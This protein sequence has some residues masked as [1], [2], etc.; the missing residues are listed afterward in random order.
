MNAFIAR[1]HV[2]FLE[3]L[4]RDRGQTM[5]EYVVV[6]GII[7]VAILVAMTAL[8]GSVSGALGKVTADL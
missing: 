1:L 3:R 2:L 6:L 8:G 7:S 4:E 5:A